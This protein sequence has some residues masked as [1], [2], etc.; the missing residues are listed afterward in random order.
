ME[1]VP[2]QIIVHHTASVAPIPQFDA[3]NK[4]HEARK[5]T[6]SSLGY[7][8]GYHYVIEKDGTVRQARKDN[9]EGCH[10]IGANTNSL[11]ICLVG[12]FNSE[13]PSEAQII[14]LGALI[15]TKQ[16]EHSLPVD[17]LYPHRHVSNTS[18]YGTRLPDDWAKQV[19]AWFELAKA[20]NVEQQTLALLHDRVYPPRDFNTNALPHEAHP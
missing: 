8:V 11:G 5:F 2:L 1:N 4:W 10:A 13:W 18:C 6:L 12:D 15:E 9:E 20:A 19:L 17:A 14:A 3:I 7:Y 16:R